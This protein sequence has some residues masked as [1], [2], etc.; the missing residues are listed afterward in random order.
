MDWINVTSSARGLIAL[1]RLP[2]P[3]TIHKT[4]GMVR[5]PAKL[6]PDVSSR[7]KA[8]F[9]STACKHR[10]NHFRSSLMRWSTAVQVK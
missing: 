4:K 9:P 3:S 7:A 2:A 5:M 10:Q 6:L 8:V 1:P